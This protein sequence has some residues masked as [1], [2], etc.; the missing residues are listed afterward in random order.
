VAGVVVIHATDRGIDQPVL[1]LPVGRH[2]MLE[3]VPVFDLH[4]SRVP[5]L[6]N[7]KLVRGAS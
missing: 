2:Q 5:W 6:C 3:A 1:L 4:L 7:R